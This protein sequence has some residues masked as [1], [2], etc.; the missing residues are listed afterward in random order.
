MPRSVFSRAVDEPCAH[1]LALMQC[2][3]QHQSA[4]KDYFTHIAPLAPQFSAP[5]HGIRP[6][7]VLDASGAD[8]LARMQ[9]PRVGGLTKHARQTGG[10]DKAERYTGARRGRYARCRGR[11]RS[12]ARSPR[13]RP[14]GLPWPPRHH[15]ERRPWAV[16]ADKGCV[17]VGG[18]AVARKVLCEP[19][20]VVEPHCLPHR[21]LVPKPAR[22][23]LGRRWL[24]VVPARARDG[25]RDQGAEPRPQGVCEARIGGYEPQVA[26]RG[27][28]GAAQQRL[29]QDE[30]AGV[31]RCFGGERMPSGLRR[32][33]RQVATRPVAPD[34]ALRFAL[35]RRRL[36]WR[37]VRLPSRTGLDTSIHVSSRTHGVNRSGRR[38]NMSFSTV[39]KAVGA[40]MIGEGELGRPRVCSSPE[41]SLWPHAVPRSASSVPRKPTPLNAAGASAPL[42]PALVAERR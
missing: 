38:R 32:R 19:E 24:A 17:T 41:P 15:S 22:L 42:R 14:R 36:H 40:F 34:A 7:Q 18:E 28:L 11:E 10:W 2:S 37:G 20:V 13:N 23:V 39:P 1:P 8:R 6:E 9:Q 29:D 16:N 4:A 21:P 33:M 25:G 12:R 27:A 3:V 26:P 35:G 5:V 30:A 31:A